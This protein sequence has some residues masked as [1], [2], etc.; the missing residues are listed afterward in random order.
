MARTFITR[1]FFPVNSQGFN[2][3]FVSVFYDDVANTLVFI[4][5]KTGA[6]VATIGGVALTTN[7]VATVVAAAD[8]AYFA[9]A[10]VIAFG[11]G[12]IICVQNYN[13]TGDAGTFQKVSTSNGTFADWKVIATEDKTATGAIGSSPI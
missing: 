5:D 6:T 1:E 3:T 13:A 9:T 12:K 11:L 4:N 8:Q 2:N 10:P 7:L